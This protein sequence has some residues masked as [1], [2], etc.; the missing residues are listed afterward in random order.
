[1]DNRSGI[2]GVVNGGFRQGGPQMQNFE[3]DSGFYGEVMGVV[4]N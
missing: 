3:S 4:S 2:N 1:M